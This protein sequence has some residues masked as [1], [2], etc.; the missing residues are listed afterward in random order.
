MPLVQN[1]IWKF[2]SDLTNRLLLWSAFS[3]L[4]GLFI[5]FATDEF[6]RGFGIQAVAWALVD[7]LIAL[8][9]AAAAVRRKFTANT[10]RKVL[11]INSGL[12]MLYILG[13]FWV[14]QTRT[15]MF[16][17]GTGWGIVLQ[18]TFLFFFDLFHAIKVPVEA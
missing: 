18:G 10:I 13:G 9:G 17:Q 6:G 2:E 14:I 16:W 3:L 8:I 11:W 1:P 4:A 7:A 12:D 15:E 5:W